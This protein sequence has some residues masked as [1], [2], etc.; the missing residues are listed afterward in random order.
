MPNTIEHIKPSLGEGVFLISDVAEILQLP[1]SKV[2]RWLIEFWEGKFSKDYRYTLGSK[3][4]RSVN[5]FT[6]IEFYT[7]YQLRS[8][9]LT[10][11]RIQKIYNQLA[12]DLDTKYPFARPLH[13]DGNSVWVEALGELIKVDGKLQLDLKSILTPF[14][15]KIDFTTDGVAERYF[16]LDNSKNIVVDPRHQFGAPTITGTNV[17]SIIINDFYNSGESIESICSLYSLS[18]VQVKDALRYYQRAA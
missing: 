13:T 3:E 6:L 10:S 15:S 16:P 11:Q 18:E 9:N 5:F 14:L 1:Y 7:F 17:K 8:M 4:S 12:K 2:R